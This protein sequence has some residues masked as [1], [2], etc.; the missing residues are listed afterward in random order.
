MQAVTLMVVMASG[1]VWV[2]VDALESEVPPAL[3]ERLQLKSAEF[4]G[5]RQ[6]QAAQIESWKQRLTSPFGGAI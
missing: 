6:A 4:L 1:P 5:L 2:G 3:V